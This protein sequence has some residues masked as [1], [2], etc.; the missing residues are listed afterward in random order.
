MPID[1]FM[2]SDPT[3][4]PAGLL[5]KLGA[6]PFL[7]NYFGHGSVEEWDNLLSGADATALTNPSLSIYVSM[8]CLNGFFHDLYTQSLA[9]SLLLAPEGGAVAVWASSTLTSF[10]P[11]A[12]LDRQFL[13]RVARTSLGQAALDAKRA[14]S[15]VD[16]RR[17]WMLFG[18]PTLLG[19]P[20]PPT[21]DA[22]PSGT[23]AS[24]ADAGGAAPDGGAPAPADAAPAGDGGATSGGD[25]AVADGGP[26]DG[27]RDGP[28]APSGSGCS[29]ALGPDPATTPMRALVPVGL[30]LL[31]LARRRR[32][33]P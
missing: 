30:G 13:S 31:L 19:T 4:T 25:G 7:V 9:E 32:R 5:A 17:T 1:R 20:S 10:D 11:Q 6:G 16:A 8:N 29:C 24:L 3:A 15:D 33:A 22:G 14:I 12:V 26:T 23:D 21:P 27:A 2:R 18:D 28:G